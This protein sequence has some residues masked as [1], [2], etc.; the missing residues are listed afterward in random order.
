MT[1]IDVYQYDYQISSIFIILK[2]YITS[3]IF[4]VDYLPYIHSNYSFISNMPLIHISLFSTII[5]CLYLL[6]E[7]LFINIIYFIDYI[8]NYNIFDNFIKNILINF[9]LCFINYI[10]I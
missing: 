6:L 9:K 7:N 1:V 5:N 4:W 8:E 10:M 2:I 3:L